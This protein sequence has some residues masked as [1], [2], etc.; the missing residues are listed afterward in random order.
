VHLAAAVQGLDRSSRL[1][2]IPFVAE[3]GADLEGYRN[4]RRSRTGDPGPGDGGAKDS[5]VIIT[6]KWR[7]KLPGHS[8]PWVGRTPA[9]GRVCP[10]GPA[11]YYAAADGQ[12]HLIPQ[13]IAGLEE[14][15]RQ[16]SREAG[17]LLTASGTVY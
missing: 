9:V 13:E 3:K 7:P 10:D 2:V 5:R 12:V 11:G 16:L 6:L 14:E 4:C 15:L 17:P 1:S 8:P